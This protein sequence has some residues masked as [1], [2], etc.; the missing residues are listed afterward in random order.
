MKS[1]KKDLLSQATRVPK[2]W[3]RHL[4][5]KGRDPAELVSF[6]GKSDKT[7]PL[8][9]SDCWQIKSVFYWIGISLGPP[10]E[11][12]NSMQM[13]WEGLLLLWHVYACLV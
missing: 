13:S 9:A 10:V 12:T 7:I 5:F 3:Q 11:F 2:F 1:R 4:T 6:A 8:A